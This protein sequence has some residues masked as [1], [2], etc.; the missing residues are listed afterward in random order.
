MDP[1]LM[2]WPVIGQ[3]S[4]ISSLGNDKDGWLCSEWL[5]SLSTSSGNM[6]SSPPLHLVFPTVDNVRCS[7]EGYP[8]GGSIP[9]SSKTALKQLIFQVSFALGSLIPVVEVAPLLTLKHT[10]GYPQIGAE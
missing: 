5:Q 7:L 6:M 8:A 9:Y 10:P 3:F 4:S 2:T 1:A